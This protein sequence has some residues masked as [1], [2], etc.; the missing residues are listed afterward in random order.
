MLQYMCDTDDA[1]V[2]DAALRVRLRDGS[3][4]K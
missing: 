3:S 2:T 4:T 1:V